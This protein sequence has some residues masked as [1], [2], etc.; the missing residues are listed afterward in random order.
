MINQWI[1]IHQTIQVSRDNAK[2]DWYT[3]KIQDVDKKYFYIDMPY[4]RSLPLV[5]SRGERVQVQIF[6]A[7]ERIA[8]KSTVFGK[9]YDNIPLFTLSIPDNYKRVQ[10]RNFVRLPIMMDAF[11]AVI[12]EDPED[13]PQF[14]KTTTLDLSGGGIR[15]AVDK[16][17][18]SGTKLLL[19]FTLQIKNMNHEVEVAGKVARSYYPDNTNTILAA[20]AFTN[21]TRRQEDLIVRFIINKMSESLSKK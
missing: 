4:Q 15:I 8:F 16:K 13:V 19:K 20:T 18:P 10:L 11:Y 7:G 21:I 6:L 9:R 14:I 1:K 3:S 2:E 12:P 17:Y 5:L